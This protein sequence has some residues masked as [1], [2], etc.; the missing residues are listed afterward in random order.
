MKIKNNIA[1]SDNGFVFN[2]GSGESFTVNPVGLVMLNMLRKGLSQSKIVATI[3]EEYNIDASS[4]ER[5]LN[6]FK[7]MMRQYR[8]MQ[9]DD[10]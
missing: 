2:P 7:E 4:V 10:E 6:D 8:L 3:I 1:V 5:D 9:H